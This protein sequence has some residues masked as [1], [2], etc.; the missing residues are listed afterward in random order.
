MTDDS[1]L[2][3]AK[4]P[5]TIL[6][7]PYGHPF[8]ALLVTIPI[9]TWTASIVFDIVAGVTGDTEVFSRAA[10]WLIGIGIVGAVL[11]AITGLLDFSQLAPR[12]KAQRTGLLHA[13]FNTLALVLFLIG[14][15]VRVNHGYDDA[16]VAGIV[17]SVIALLCV[18]VSGT[19]G[20]ELAYRYGIRVADEETQREAFERRD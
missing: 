6:A 13:G 8:H 3:K 7:G 10:A 17:L 16:S 1:A 15:I 11:A 5:R 20:G 19:L 4:R 12:T 9:G 18:A 2:R 14:L